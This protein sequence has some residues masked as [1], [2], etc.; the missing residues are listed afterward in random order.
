MNLYE[1][2]FVEVK[3]GDMIQAEP[4]AA[5]AKSLQEVDGSVRRGGAAA[6]VSDV[7][8]RGTS[9]LHYLL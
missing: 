9:S 4:L 6:G 3:W 1:D 5:Y 8:A 7:R 2:Q